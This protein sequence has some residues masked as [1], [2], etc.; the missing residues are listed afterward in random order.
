MGLGEV[1]KVDFGAT[2]AA[3]RGPSILKGPGAKFE[4]CLSK[5]NVVVP[6]LGRGRVVVC[7]EHGGVGPTPFGNSS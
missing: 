3:R 2:G 5:L 1:S 4:N 6:P 7:P